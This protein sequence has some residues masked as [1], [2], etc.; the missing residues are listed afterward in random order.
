MLPG[1]LKT[2]SWLP[3]A[4]RPEPLGKPGELVYGTRFVGDRLYAV[5]FRMTDPLY[6]VDLADSAD[7]RIAGALEIPGF[8]EYLHPLPNGLL[9]GFGK[10]AIPAG[11]GGDGLGAWFQGLQLSLFDV[12][13]ASAPR[14]IRRITVGKRGSESALLTSHHAFSA[15]ARPDGSTTIA[16]PAA[17]HEAYPG[18]VSGPWNSYGWSYSGVLRFELRGSTAAD[19]RLTQLPTMVTQRVGPVY[20]PANDPARAGGRT[21][22]F[23]DGD[24]Y[25]GNGFFWRGDAA[26]NVAGPY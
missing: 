3:N 21:V 9:L 12:S 26:G 6:V 19:V 13:N 7:P 8:S 4:R 14:E 20:G 22:Q 17:V 1:L 18:A 25:S 5:T 15:F 11:G 2:V 23:A 24:I 10:D 16:I